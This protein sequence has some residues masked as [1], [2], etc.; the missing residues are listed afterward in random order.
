MDARGETPPDHRGHQ[1]DPARR[2][3]SFAVTADRYRRAVTG[4]L[5][6]GQEGPEDE[7]GSR[8]RPDPPPG[9]VLVAVRPSAGNAYSLRRFRSPG[10]TRCVVAFTSWARLAA[11]LGPDHPAIPV[12]LPALRKLVAPLGIGAPAVDPPLLTAAPPR[13]GP[14]GPAP[15][16]RTGGPSGP[17]IPPTPSTA[18]TRS[19]R[20]PDGIHR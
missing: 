19:S 10:G 6:D 16:A 4:T 15:Q 14:Q 9:I 20:A 17:P 13:A 2:H 5:P 8:A 11:V 7:H 12:A 1:P 3:R 18:S